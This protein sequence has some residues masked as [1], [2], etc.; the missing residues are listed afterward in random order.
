MNKGFTLVELIIYIAIIGLIVTGFATFS[1]AISNNREKSYVVSEVHANL[2]DAYSLVTKRIRFASSI[3]TPSS[4]NSSTTLELDMPGANPNL[5]FKVIDN[6]LTIQEGAG[7]PV[8]L[9]SDEVN[10]SEF[11]LTNYAGVG[12]RDN[13][14]IEMTVE[15]GSNSNDPIYIYNKS[16]ETTVRVRK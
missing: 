10:F 4:G 8:A 1:I 13:L 11:T 9:T 16:L 6:I 15:Y 3:V 14:K 12:R 5:I 2:R 7:S